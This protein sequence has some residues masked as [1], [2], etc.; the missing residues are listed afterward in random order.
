MQ[1][2]LNLFENIESVN[3]GSLQKSTKQLLIPPNAF[4]KYNSETCLEIEFKNDGLSNLNKIYS[5][6]RGLPGFLNN[7]MRGRETPDREIILNNP[8][9]CL[10]SSDFRYF[11]LPGGLDNN[12]HA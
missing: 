9:L 6:V 8:N 5:E 10:W 11:I 1:S 2:K 4:K 12:P 3:E 7:L